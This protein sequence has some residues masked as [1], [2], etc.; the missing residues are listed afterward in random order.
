MKIAVAKGDGIGPEI[1]DA[2]LDIF[3]ANKVPLEYEIVDMGKWVF[4]KG[5]SNGMT[6]ESQQVIE[7]LGILFKGPM[8]TPKG[9]GVKSI[10]VTARKT[11]NTYANKRVF[12]SLHGVDTVFSKAGIP[13]DITIVRENIEDTYGGIE[14]MPTH[15]VALSRRF[16]TRPGSLQV[17]RYAFEMAKKNGAR[18]ITCGHK[19]NIMKLTD[20]LFLECFQEVAKEYPELK[21]DDVIVDD[22]AMKLVV[23]PQEFD[24]VVLTNLQGDIISDLCAGLVGGLGFAPSA[25]I[26][27][28]ISIFEAVH[29]T[30]PDIA[31]K[32]IANPTA[33]LLS[34]IS[35]LRHLGLMENAAIIEN[36]LLYTL[37]QGIHTGDFG[38]KSIPA[39]NTTEFAR[40]IINNFGKTPEHGAKPILPNMHVTPT[41]FKIDQNQMMVSDDSADEKEY[42]VGVDMFIESSEQPEYI[43]KKCLRHGGVKFKLIN[44]S[45]RGTQVWPT[46]SVYTNLV[47]QYNARFESIDGTPL[48]QTDIIGLYVSLSGDFKIGSFELLNVMNGKKAYSLAQ[49]Q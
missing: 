7:K 45:N 32:N 8:E 6:P 46:G 30:A 42:I 23:R 2:V 43:A 49:G 13:I 9:K 48:I 41:L 27:D 22:L 12:I 40:A 20:G 5:F 1:M 11:W 31:G 26:G 37:E 35:M 47:N 4:D 16:I 3:N 29:G 18:R 39:K 10:N 19:A 34:G 24:V 28:H 33:L 36:A 38:N 21:S 14:H 17:I 15:D 25:N 44:I